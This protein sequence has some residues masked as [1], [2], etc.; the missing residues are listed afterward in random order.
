M[1]IKS[2]ARTVLSTVLCRARSI[3]NPPLGPYR[4]DL[5]DTTFIESL[6]SSSDSL[7]AAK[8]TFA[9]GHHETAR[10]HVVR[11]F[12]HRQTP[13]FFC[14]PIQIGTLTAILLRDRTAW[15]AALRARVDQDLNVG[16]RIVSMRGGPLAGQF[17]WAGIQPGPGDDDLFSA[18]P[19]R[20][21]FLPRLALAAHYGMPTLGVIAQLINRWVE[22][23]EAGKGSGYLS[24]LVV[25]YRV[26]ALNWTFVFAAGLH[27]GG[28]APSD[29]LLFLILKILYADTEYLKD[30]IGKSYP[31]N[32][33]LADGFAGWYFGTMFPEF[34]SAAQSRE[35]GEELFLREVRRQFYDD[36][37]NFEHSTHYHELGCEMAL[38]YL[39]LS[40]RNGI[41]PADDIVERLKRML[42]FQLVLFGPEAIPLA[43]GDSTE[44][45]LFPLDAEHGWG[46]GAMRELYRAL[47]NPNVDAA[48]QD[49][50]T[51]ER[52]YWLLTGE[53]VAPSPLPSPSGALPTSFDHGGFYMLADCGRRARLVFRSGPAENEP[54]SAG[55]AHSDL[56]NVYLSVGGVPLIVGAGT[57]TYRF[58]TARWPPSTPD[59]RSYFAGPDSHNGLMLG[60]DPYGAMVG[61]FRSRDVP[62]R[63]G[64]RRR[65][66]APL[67]AWLEFEVEGANVARG[68]RRGVVHIG[69][70][71]WV[72]YDLVPNSIRV[73][74]GA[75][76]GLQFAPGSRTSIA[77]GPV[78]DVTL[79]GQGC[80]IC[81][82]G[83]FRDP[84]LLVGS[85]KPL[86]GW[87]SPRYGELVPAPQ[88]RARI[89]PGG[90]PCGFV[91]Q[92]SRGEGMSCSI[93]AEMVGNFC[94][95]FRMVDREFVDVL[96]VRTSTSDSL[97]AAWDVEFGGA[98]AWLRMVEDEIVDCRL[99]G[100]GELRYRGRSIRTAD[101]AVLHLS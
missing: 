85:T 21:G 63:V 81:L 9:A 51:V 3:L 61:D 50:L 94:I 86:A 38:A 7:H 5:S 22:A 18:Q 67:L 6:L 27:T 15:V 74:E 41:E 90:D 20:Y 96:L 12:V 68:C 87:V 32:H 59:W 91:I 11:H 89:A 99:A 88:L 42:A 75:S 48:P 92:A 78:I 57:Y 10:R 36:G 46:A 84:K 55:H 71:Y 97:M 35:V 64:L 19:H 73:M 14:D 31:N 4:P 60:A 66:Q 23:T 83:G 69:G 62:C 8:E 17:E 34:P 37:A 43:I 54:I 1:G 16:L 80:R 29:D 24:P 40:R 45:P 56:L 33:L 100:V 13:K 58:K 101:I 93:V 95:A 82:S 30:T 65:V 28:D 25:L 2:T 52:A 39:L 77:D 26:L 72:I 47:F 70:H 49:D 53:L 76:I 98:L 79:G 44:D